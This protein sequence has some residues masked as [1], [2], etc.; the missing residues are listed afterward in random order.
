MK[1][2][3]YLFTILFF[4]SLHAQSLH[5]VD[6]EVVGVG[7]D[8]TWTDA[9]GGTS[10]LVNN[11]SATGINTSAKVISLTKT[12]TSQDWALTFTS[13]DG[14]FTFDAD[15]DEVKVK[16]YKPVA[17]NFCIKFE[18]SSTPK[19]ICVANT[20]TNTWE[21][22]TFDF[23]EVIGNSYNKIVI[24]PDNAASGAG[25]HYFDDLVVPDGVVVVDP[26]P[27]DAP[28][29]P[30]EDSSAVLSLF[31][32]AYTD[33]AAVWNPSWGQSTV[34][35]DVVIAS[36][37]V[38]K[39]SSFNYSG[40]EPSTVIEVNSYN[41]IKLDYWTADATAIKVKFV[42]YGQDKSY[43]E[44][45]NV[46]K[47]L[48]HTISEE[49]RSSWQTLQFN[50]STFG[51]PT[52]NIGQ[53]VLSH[54]GEGTALVYFDNIYFSSTT[55]SNEKRLFEEFSVYPNPVSDR[56]SIS[57]AE[58]IDRL[59]IYDLTGK[60]VKQASP[61][62]TAFSVDVSGLSKGVYLVKLN[63]GDREATTKMIK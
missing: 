58:S 15:N 8:W 17:S 40:I 37:N 61:Q 3:Y 2:L 38:K 57:A 22:L 31:S 19:E 5:T 51:V 25:V 7:N 36:N 24:I 21:E 10:S 16:V 12:A 35:E 30:S 56:V 29:T 20:Q 48:T 63:T 50:I 39:Y 49:A 54:G 59:R 26:A 4:T 18:G 28:T 43:D 27:T 13:D 33:V 6:F 41:S 11:P 44:T 60:L 1:D 32:D 46:E 52:G 9:E 55:L 23:S 47:E 42:D 34:V 62:K 14:T 53:I 45:T